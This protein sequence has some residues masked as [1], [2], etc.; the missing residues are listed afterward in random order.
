MKSATEGKER[1]SDEERMTRKAR[2]P[3]PI[4][5]TSASCTL[6]TCRFQTRRLANIGPVEPTIALF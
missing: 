5:E 1:R 6:E 2:E 3:R 4:E